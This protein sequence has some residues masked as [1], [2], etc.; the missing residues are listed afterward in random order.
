MVAFVA[1]TTEETVGGTLRRLHLL[2]SS[3]PPTRRSAGGG[4]ADAGVPPRPPTRVPVAPT[5]PPTGRPRAR[6]PVGGAVGVTRAFPYPGSTPDAVL[7]AVEGWGPPSG[8]DPRLAGR[9]DEGGVAL[10]LLRQLLCEDPVK[11]PTAVA[12][13]QHPWFSPASGGGRG[14]APRRARGGL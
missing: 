6:R 13:L 3:P 14:R 9:L 12:A 8:A 10:S 4:C 2:R 7:E 11:R 5:A 1:V